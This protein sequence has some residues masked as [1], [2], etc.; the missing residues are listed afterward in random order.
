VRDGADD[1]GHAEVHVEASSRKMDCDMEPVLVG[2]ES[3]GLTGEGWAARGHTEVKDFLDLALRRNLMVQVHASHTLGDALSVVTCVVGGLAIES[4][5][6]VLHGRL[7][8]VLHGNEERHKLTRAPCG[9]GDTS[10]GQDGARGAAAAAHGLLVLTVELGRVA[11]IVAVADGK[12]RDG[13]EAAVVVPPWT[14]DVCLEHVGDLTVLGIKVRRKDQV[15]GSRDGERQGVLTRREEVFLESVLREPD[16]SLKVD[17][18]HRVRA[19]DCA[20]PGLVSVRVGVVFSLSPMSAGAAD[21]VD[22]HTTG[23]L[24][25][26]QVKHDRTTHGIISAKE[27]TL[28]ILRSDIELSRSLLEQRHFSSSN[29]FFL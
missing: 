11:R 21:K 18:F 17:D 27:H 16:R 3:C 19:G 29:F 24:G 2:N 5:A 25:L 23:L 28:P 9:D 13:Q 10:G 20:S 4:T 14:I 7:G 8:V 1:G 22:E 15:G 12:E 6:Y 26:N